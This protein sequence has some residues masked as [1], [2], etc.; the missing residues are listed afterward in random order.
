MGGGTIVDESP[1]GTYGRTVGRSAQ[2]NQSVA[3]LWGALEGPGPSGV[4]KPKKL[5]DHIDINLINL[6]MRVRDFN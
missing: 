4:A 3:S 2:W 6:I 1:I 5:G